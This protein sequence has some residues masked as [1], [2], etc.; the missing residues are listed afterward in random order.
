M[1]VSDEGSSNFR[2]RKRTGYQSNRNVAEPWGQYLLLYGYFLREFILAMWNKKAFFSMQVFQDNH[3]YKNKTLVMD[4]CNN[5]IEFFIKW[6]LKR[7]N[8]F[9]KCPY[10]SSKNHSILLNKWTIKFMRKYIFVNKELSLAKWCFIFQYI[11]L[12]CF[13]NISNSIT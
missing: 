8:A 9:G 6:I 3:Q 11:I 13:E 5:L 7:K 10:F 1:D 2:K 12:M 4:Y